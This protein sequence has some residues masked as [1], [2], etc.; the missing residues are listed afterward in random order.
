M[1]YINQEIKKI[2]DAGWYNLTDASKQAIVGYLEI[3]L[4]IEKTIK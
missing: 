2:M 3:S 4:A 1:D